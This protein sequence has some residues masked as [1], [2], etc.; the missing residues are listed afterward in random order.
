MAKLIDVCHFNKSPPFGPA[1]AD[2]FYAI[3]VTWFPH[4]AEACIRMFAVILT[5]CMQ[6]HNRDPR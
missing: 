6:V 2:I 3:V 4:S 5:A 1:R